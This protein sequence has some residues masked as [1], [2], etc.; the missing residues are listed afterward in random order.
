[1]VKC[2]EEPVAARFARDVANHQMEIR[3]EDGLYRHIVFKQTDTMN[4]MFSLTT[5][6]GRL[7]Y[8][9]DMGC[10]V[11]QRL[12]DM[13]AFFRRRKPV[14]QPNFGYWAEKIV[15]ADREGVKKPSVD[16][17]RE[18]LKSYDTSG[19][20]TEEEEA[21]SEFIEEACNEY[22]TD[23]PQCAFRSVYDFSLDTEG[24]REQFFTDFFE[25]EDTDYTFRFEWACYAIQFGIAMYDESKK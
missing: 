3:H 23:G 2:S 20:T 11:F 5:T 25:H 9:G 14:E 21:V 24:N 10:F 17:F 1:M 7:I 12:E 13:F 15:A 18:N 16:K 19:L 22:E 6:P 8:A 4:M